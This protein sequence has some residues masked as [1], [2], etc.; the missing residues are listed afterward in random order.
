MKNPEK[1][2]SQGLFSGEVSGENEMVSDE[3]FD[4]RLS[5]SHESVKP[6]EVLSGSGDDY[7]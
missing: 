7:D 5:D 6:D 1:F 4:E 3:K 2:N